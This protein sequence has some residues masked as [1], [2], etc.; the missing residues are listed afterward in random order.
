M[1][2]FFA[3]K[4]II[5]IISISIIFVVVGIT[6]YSNISA[7]TVS[8]TGSTFSHDPSI[9]KTST[10]WW[11][12]YTADGVGLKSSSNGSA[13]TQCSSVFPSNLSWWSTYVPSKTDKNIW[14]P[15]IFY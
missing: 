9:I 3:R 13:W 10:G 12:F 4:K 14:A 2:N 8:V 6:L 15:E 7:G 5:A 1:K 11:Q